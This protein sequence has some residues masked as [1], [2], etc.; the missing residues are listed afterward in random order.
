MDIIRG[1]SNLKPYQLGSVATIGNFDGVHLAHQG[2]L[3]HTV[4]QAQRLQTLS[5][6]ILF[7]PQ[8]LEY[9]RDDP[10]PRIQPLRDS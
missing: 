2:I 1:L 8:P 6:T 7:E 4:K 5:T 3:Q 9:L 10:P